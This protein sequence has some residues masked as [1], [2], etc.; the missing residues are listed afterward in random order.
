MESVH[1][2]N[3]EA[4]TDGLARGLGWFSLAL[5]A[6]ELA[7]PKQ[8]ARGIGV[9]VGAKTSTIMR[10]LGAREVL[11]GL[12]VLVAPRRSL[13]LWARVAGDAID[14]ILLGSAA[15]SRSAAVRLAGAAVAVAGVAAI[16]VIAARRNQKA[17]ASSPIMYSVTI[18]KPP[19]DVY[20]FYRDFT[21]FP[22]FMH[23]VESVTETGA[24]SRW[25]AKLPTGNTITWD[26][27][28]IEDRPEELIEWESIDGA[29]LKLHGRVTFEKTPGRNMTEVRV[30]LTVGPGSTA[31]AKLFAKPQIK[32][33]LRRFKQVMETGEVL[34]S[35]ASRH[36]LP[37]PAQPSNKGDV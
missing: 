7:M 31:L 36:R 25:V 37:H 15:R 11:S 2:K 27:R 19:G 9:P 8:L 4:H 3:T 16:D 1:Q 24:T 35:D 22:E 12:A 26:A 29:P 34:V 13:P 14:L 33:D 5:G 30:E 23:Y 6:A 10:V 18:N 28:L 17:L 20:A 32:G 21:R